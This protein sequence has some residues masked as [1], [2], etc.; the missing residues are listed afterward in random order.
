MYF[1][2][3]QYYKRILTF[4][5]TVFYLFL[6]TGVTLLETHCVCSDSTSISLYTT[7][8]SCNEIIS[9]HTCCDGENTCTEYFV[10]NETHSCGCNEPIVTYL[11]LTNHFGEDSVLEYPIVQKLCVVYSPETVSFRVIISPESSV[12]PDYLP[13]ENPLFGRFLITFL[14]QRKIA[15]TA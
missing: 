14:S 11:K 9:D 6:S 10:G 1:C 8:E 12:Y 2:C 7:S 3:M 13:P 5:F 15:L 4:I